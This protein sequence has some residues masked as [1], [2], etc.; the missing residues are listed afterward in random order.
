MLKPPPGPPGSDSRIAVVAD[1]HIGGPGGAGD[2]LFRQLRQ[3]PAQGCTDLLLLGDLFHVWVGSPKYETA[4]IREFVGVAAELRKAGL[5][6]HYIE[7]NRDFFLAG[8]VYSDCFDRYGLEA[9]FD[10]VDTRGRSV[11]ILAVHGDRANPNDRGYRLWA[12]ISKS[13]PVRFFMRRLPSRLAHALVHKA[14]RGI[15][16]TNQKYRHSIPEKELRAYAQRRLT[17]NRESDGYDLL[18]M[19]HFHQPASFTLESG[20]VR[21]ID[22]WFNSRQIEWLPGEGLPGEPTPGEPTPGK[23]TTGERLP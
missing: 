16:R 4:D 6:L 7:G 19:G 9:D 17:G 12:A 18:V 21:L 5:R 10:A 11:R 22:A 2:E 8:S 3:L 14:E 1:A 20:E 15:A 13:P 23:P